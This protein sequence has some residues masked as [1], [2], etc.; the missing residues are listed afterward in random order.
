MNNK[1]KATV[2]KHGMINKGDRVIV[3]LSGGADSAVLLDVMLKL[4]DE[5]ELT[6]CAA[7]V[8]HHLRG[9]E[10]QRDED[11]VRKLCR[12]KGVELFVKDADV[13]S[14]AE[15]NKESMELAGRKVRYE[16]FEELCTDNL[17][18]IAT[19]HT[20]S[21]ALETAIFNMTRGA[22]LSGLCS[23]PYV[24]GRFIRPL[25]DVTRDEI[26]K[27]AKENFVQ[28]VNDSTNSDPSLCSRNS[29][30]H[31]VVPVL[32]DIN[33]SAEENYIKLRQQLS[34]IESF[35]HEEAT[36]LLECAKCDYGYK[37][38]VI[39]ASHKAV[40]NY[41]LKIL[42][43][44][45]ESKHI[46]LMDSLLVS[47]GAVNLGSDVVAVVKQGILRIVH[48]NSDEFHSISFK[49]G[50]VFTAFGNIYSVKEL[51]EEDI[52]YKKL[53]TLCI[54]CDKISH[55]AVFRTRKS[56]DRFSPRGRGITK[57]LRKLQNELRIPHELRDKLLLLECGGEI[58]WAEG[59]GVSEKGRYTKGNGIL[60]DV[61]GDNYAQGL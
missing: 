61:K 1:V 50:N 47:E 49:T 6:L 44:N 41:A 37:C 51:S 28:F 60:I 7:H 57:D 18:K 4:R 15:N 54:G 17:T 14:V 53:A 58:L 33:D 34:E 30:R 2:K 5:Y 25:L 35:M 11:F 13:L 59:I 22:S 19:A 42:A 27:Y 8:N 38:S 21:D 43:K 39:A 32:K 55:D 16:F 45:A 24:R 40:R 48:E 12:E 52:V 36:N 56:G 23:I 26:E 3:A 9:D 20:A 46:E 31:K 10:S 29:I